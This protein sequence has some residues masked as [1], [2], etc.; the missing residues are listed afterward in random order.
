MN[1]YW[2]NL[3]TVFLIATS[4]IFTLASDGEF[5]I[6]PYIFATIWLLIMCLNQNYNRR[7]NKKCPL[8]RLPEK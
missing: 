4:F 7:R 2:V 3:V 1:R 5:G 6:Y 8:I